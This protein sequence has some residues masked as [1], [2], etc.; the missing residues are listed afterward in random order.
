MTDANLLALISHG[1]AALNKSP[2]MPPYG[3][4]LTKAEVDA[5]AA[6][7]RAVADPPYR[8]QGVLYA[9]N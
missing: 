7:I 9:G 6:Y 2:A 8:K 3:N 4:T 1:G 5:L